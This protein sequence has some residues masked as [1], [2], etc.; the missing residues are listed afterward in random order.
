MTLLFFL[1]GIGE[2]DINELRPVLADS[3]IIDIIL[4][5]FYTAARYSE[6][7]ILLVFSYFLGKKASVLKTYSAAVSIY[8]VVNFL[9]FLP[10]VLILGIDFAQHTLN[11][12]WVFSRQ[13]D[14][15]DSERLHP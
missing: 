14:V 11:P 3:K 12:Y 8:L 13:V 4:G 6:I 15:L 9:I 10:P 5:A 1:L 7:L 2:M